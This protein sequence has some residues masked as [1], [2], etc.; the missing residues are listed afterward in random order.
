[1]KEIK[2]DLDNDSRIIDFHKLYFMRNICLSSCV[3]ILVILGLTS[4]R[5]TRDMK[6]FQ[7][8]N[9]E[10]LQGHPIKAPEYLIK[11]D[12][13][14][15]VDIQS[16]N[17]EVSQLFSPTKSGSYSGGTQSE[18]GDV[19]SQYLNGFLVNQKGRILLPVIGE[20]NVSGLNEESARD[21]IQRKVNEYYKDATVKVK[22]LTY[23]VTV[24]G[25]VRNPGVYYNY[26]KSMTI[27]DALGKANGTTDYAS[28]RR[29]LVIRP[30]ASGSRS[31]RI[32]LTG[33]K[34]MTSEAFYLLPND[35]LYVE[36]DKY[37]N[38][39]LNTTV[40]TMAISAITTS[41]LILN[42]LNQ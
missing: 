13:N 37:K 28:V 41:I 4:C 15:Y 7:D 20:V 24:L 18:F 16:L 32:D 2:N 23:K 38:F 35:V 33:K 40:Y 22:I 25:E 30:T 1:M 27:L 21:T 36:P 5:S 14:L 12:D 10:V 11:P 42:Y 39:S 26:N 9:N 6:Y 31:Y 34:L 3:L 8:L 19:S 17:P 29:L